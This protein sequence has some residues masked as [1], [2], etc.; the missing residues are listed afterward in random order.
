VPGHVGA[1]R[2][3]GRRQ[4]RRDA[5]VPAH[6]LENAIKVRRKQLDALLDDRLLKAKRLEEEA[7]RARVAADPQL[8]AASGEPW[9]DIARA[10]L[11]EQEL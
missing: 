8:A 3:R 9:S 7:L 4:A 6:N 11:R 1:A 2:L 10:E 5:G